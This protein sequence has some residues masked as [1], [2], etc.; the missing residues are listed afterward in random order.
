MQVSILAPQ[1]PNAINVALVA[2]DSYESVIETARA[3]K[4]DLS[5]AVARNPTPQPP[6][7]PQPQLSTPHRVREV[8]SA[9][10]FFDVRCKKL[11]EEQLGYTN[12]IEGDEPGP[13]T[14]S[15][16]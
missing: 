4:R 10:E 13:E 9:L 6:Q 8:L 15:P 16:I 2:C 11:V 5:E 7:P 1:K 3:A 12:P 14:L